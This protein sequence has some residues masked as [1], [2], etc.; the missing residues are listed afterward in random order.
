MRTRLLFAIGLAIMFWQIM[1][2]SKEECKCEDGSVPCACQPELAQADAKT[3]SKKPVKNQK[4][5]IVKDNEKLRIAAKKRKQVQMQV[6]VLAN[7]LTK[8]NNELKLLQKEKL[9][10]KPK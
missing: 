1:A 7:M 8:L 4:L 10:A 3:T 9:T 5:V 6:K 2:D